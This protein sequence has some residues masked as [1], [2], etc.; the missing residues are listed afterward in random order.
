MGLA[1][2]V[3]CKATVLLLLM[4]AM[5]AVLRGRF[6]LVCSVLW[7]ATLVG[8]LLL[9]LAVVAF[10][11]WRI[12]LLPAQPVARAVEVQPAPILAAPVPSLEADRAGIE[13]QTF[14][15]PVGSG[16]SI[17]TQAPAL[18]PAPAQDPPSGHLLPGGEK[19]APAVR[20]VDWTLMAVVVYGLG[21]CVLALRLA[22]SLVSVAALRRSSDSVADLL[23]LERLDS[24]R[25][26]LGI[27]QA[28][29]LTRSERT[30]VPVLVGWW[31]PSIV[32][33]AALKGFDSAGPIDAVL[34]H[35]L[36]HARRG[37]YAWNL[38]LKLVQVVYWPHPLVWPLKRLVHTVRE[39]A[40]DDLCVR[41]LGDDRVYRTT[42]LDVAAGL[43]HRPGPALGMAM[44][45]T[46][47]LERRL[48]R[49]A[50]SRG[51]ARCQL[52]APARVVIVMAV[53]AAAGMLGSLRLARAVAEV[54]QPVPE[55]AKSEK[56]EEP[57]AER[58]KAS[59]P[60]AT[61]KDDKT[62]PD[63]KETAPARSETEA[64]T[65]SAG[66]PPPSDQSELARRFY[67]HPDVVGIRR[68][69]EQAE[70]R[71]KQIK[72][73]VRPGTNDPSLIHAQGRLRD[74]NRELAAVWKT[75]APVLQ[76]P[77]AP[78]PQEDAP[79]KVQTIR[80]KRG[81][82]LPWHGQGVVQA[83]EQSAVRAR[84]AG[85]LLRRTVELGDH[86]KK[87]QALAELDVPDLEDDV[88]MA[89]ADLDLARAQLKQAEA[90]IRV[91]Q[92]GVTIQ[93]ATLK[94]S[95]VDVDKAT[96]E[97][98]YRVKN[99]D[100][101]RKLSDNNAISQ[102]A[103]DEAESKRKSADL[104]VLTAKTAALAAEGGVAQARDQLLGAQAGLEGA[105]QRVA[106]ATA[107]HERATRQYGSARVFSPIDGVVIQAHADIGTLIRPEADQP[108][109][110]VARTDKVKV[111][112]RIESALAEFADRGDA[113]VVNFGTRKFEAQVARVAWAY[114]GLT[115]PAEIDLDNPGGRL[116]PGQ[117]AQ[118]QIT[119]ENHPDSWA[120]PY[121]AVIVP[122]K[123]GPDARPYVICVESGRTVRKMVQVGLPFE[124]RF[125]GT[126]EIL[127]GLTGNEH[128]VLVPRGVF[129]QP[130]ELLDGTRLEEKF[131]EEWPTPNRRGGLQ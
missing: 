78:D 70:Q 106:R 121:S 11:H 21:V 101:Q 27:G 25:T 95:Q 9:P 41:W 84:V 59:P 98:A 73:V 112:V 12:S 5:H 17:P 13:V 14:G 89:L 39:Q 100:R 83:Y 109:F 125:P 93:E 120:V 72:R 6:T 4:L 54:Q 68:E 1:L 88:K 38:L 90:A 122:E 69:K 79:L 51:A 71:I 108:L 53:L 119:L 81:Y 113:V 55:P 57:K 117:T 3:A 103:W 40:C 58:Q 60:D 44:A 63:E 49:I 85:V 80:P 20:A 22:R 29:T 111:A 131:S 99:S 76:K 16:V 75:L 104:A 56:A 91:A 45:R 8:L 18:P 64:A 24:W 42:L 102:D 36:A 61:K 107:N 128:I 52:R 43:V 23:W 77:D 74:L 35:E 10:P 118:V 96:A 92:G 62:A 86:V 123:K 105:R 15:A 127:A 129:P 7:N 50:S 94:G 34:L 30:S 126:I 67:A 65:D 82:E 124:F 2:D 28:V 48:T 87:G 66:P 33:P 116:R 114:E 110:L 26:R 37:D 32:L 19:P 115:L 130:R 97:L 46:S 47:G 31:R